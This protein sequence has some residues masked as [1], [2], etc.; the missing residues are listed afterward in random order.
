MKK[1]KRRIRFDRIF[2]F[3]FCVFIIFI[4]IYCIL[5]LKISNIYVSGN[6]YLSDQKIIELAGIDDYPSSI[7][8][9]SFQIENRLE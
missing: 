8:N 1:K 2:L 5:N 4:I 6:S 9:L 7:K 3:L